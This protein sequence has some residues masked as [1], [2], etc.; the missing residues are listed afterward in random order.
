MSIKAKYN[1]LSFFYFLTTVCLGGFIAIFLQY[2]GVSNTQIGL[3]TGAACIIAIFLT[4]MISMK[5]AKS[6]F[7]DAKKALFYAYIII[8]GIYALLAFFSFHPVIIA[9]VYMFIYAFYLATGQLLQ[10]MASDY[11]Q[12]GDDVNFGLARGLGSVAWALG[13][14][15]FGFLVNIFNPNLLVIGM[16]LFT[17]IMFR[18]LSKM[19]YK[20]GITTNN[21]KSNSILSV[22]KKYPIFVIVLTGFSLA[23]A[24]AT[25]IGT[26]LINIVDNLG[27]NASFYGIAVFF[28]AVSEMP[29]MAITPRLLKRFKSIY[30]IFFAGLCYVIRNF[31]ICL[32]PNIFIL[33]IGMIFQGLSFGMLTA[34]ITYYVIFNFDADDQV[35]GQTMIIMMT[36]GFGSM[37]GNLFG[38]YLQDSFGLNA[39]FM[40]IY[41]LTIIGV[42]LIIIGVLLSQHKKLK[43]EIKR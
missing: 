24:A 36:S 7:L 18:I 25:S 6:R 23:L 17:L 27:G 13:A 20:K 40:F 10:V 30:L 32:A 14:L 3:V 21:K 19:P 2:K 29:I 28:M 8:T 38:G 43:K 11:I 34:V 26:Y 4:P 37:I 15:I 9:F 12:A 33:C 42:V 31:L 35:E 16:T 5:V 1:W 41:I 39:M 22:I